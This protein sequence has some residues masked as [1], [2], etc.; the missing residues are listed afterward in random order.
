MKIE[1]YRKLK[2]GKYKV[3]LDNG[4]EL[5]LYED[6][7]LK[8]NLLLKKQIDNN[9]IDKLNLENEEEEI[10]N[11]CLKYISVR[12]RSVSEIKRYLE[13]KEVEED[14]SNAIINRLIKNNY[15]NDL[16]FLK[17]F[18]IDKINLTNDG[19][20]KIIN[21]LKNH[22]IDTNLIDEQLYL[23]QNE[24]KEKI[25]KIIE[26]SIKVNKKYSGFVLKNKIY[27]NLVNLGYDKSMILSLINNY[28]FTNDD[29]KE[30]YKKLY[31]KYKNKYDKDKLDLVIKQKLYQKGYSYEDI[32]M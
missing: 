3:F 5:T 23:Y 22:D 1:K 4:L 16:M 13:N 8:N 20:Y 25:K 15:L 14:I 24:F 2:S 18:V 29:I 28:N 30:V 21:Q 12:I 10:Y 9:L 7:I 27:N 19:P 26:K 11:S 32:N 6:V 31:E 17:Y